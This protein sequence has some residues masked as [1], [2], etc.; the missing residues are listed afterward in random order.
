MKKIFSVFLALILFSSPSVA[1][2]PFK[3]AVT[4]TS[5][6]KVALTFDDGPNPR[7]TDIVLDILREYGIKATFFVIGENAELYPEPLKRAIEEGHEIGNHTYSHPHMRKLSRLETEK[8]ILLC[9]EILCEGFG[10]VPSVFRPPEGFFGEFEEEITK[11]IGLR[12]VLWSIDTRDWEGK[13][14]KKIVSH[15]KESIKSGKILL[16]HDYVSGKNT[17]IPAL[18]EIIPYLLS[19]GYE[20]CTVSELML[21]DQK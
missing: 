18:R 7:Y 4:D 6:K 21:L 19:N 2:K 9:Q 11:N 15:V 3:E 1:E 14:A 5:E 20:F 10:V 12:T 13:T 17:T 16:F 8:E